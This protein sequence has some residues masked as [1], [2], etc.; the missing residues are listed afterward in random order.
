VVELELEVSLLVVACGLKE[1]GDVEIAVKDPLSA[2]L[3]MMLEA[4]AGLRV[5]VCG[6]RVTV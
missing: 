5:S 3:A 6:G 1:R 4:S 2:R